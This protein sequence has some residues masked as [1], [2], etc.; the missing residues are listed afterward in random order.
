MEARIASRVQSVR[1]VYLARAIA[2][3]EFYFNLAITGLIFTDV[4]TGLVRAFYQSVQI[5][6]ARGKKMLR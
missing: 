4:I 2:R 1:A 6:V 3:V 5:V